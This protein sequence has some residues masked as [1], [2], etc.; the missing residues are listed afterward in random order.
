MRMLSMWPSQ[1]TVSRA[2]HLPCCTPAELFAG[3][4]HFSREERDMLRAITRT[5]VS[6][7]GLTLGLSL[8][9][10]FAG[11][12]DAAAQATVVVED[13]SKHEVGATGIPAGWK[14]QN[15]GSPKNDFVV[16]EGADRALHMRCNDDGST[17]SKEVKVDIKQHQ[18]LAWKWT[19]TVLPK[20]ADSRHKAT[21]DQAAQICVLFP[22][23]PQAVRSRIYKEEPGE[24][25]RAHGANTPWQMRRLVSG[26]GVI[27]AK[28]SRN[29]S[30]SN[31]NSRVPS[32]HAV[33]SSSAMLPSRRSRRHPCANGGRKTWRASRSSPARSC[34]D[35]H[36]LA[37]RSKPSRCACRGPPDVTAAVSRVSTSRRTRAPARW[38]SAT[39]PLD[40][41]SHD[42]CQHGRLVREP[43]RRP[44]RLVGRLQAVAHQQPLTRWRIVA[45]AAATSTSLGPGAG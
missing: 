43:I 27:A 34:A 14:A 12:T 15:W 45:N 44:G 38:P 6:T 31:T 21:D 3:I 35:T 24:R 10:T 36:T 28:R 8:A 20:G 5:L 4:P 19:A 11:V 37:C 32:C 25:Q 18:I 13:W 40:R 1:F 26:R 22:R 17:I 30:G 42:L 29:S 7:V 16:A 39:R 2:P 41:G 33:F 9:L 23:F